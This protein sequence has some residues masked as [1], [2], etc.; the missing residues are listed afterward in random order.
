MIDKQIKVPDGM[1]ERA[2]EKFAQIGQEDSDAW[3]HFQAG[4]EFALQDI[5]DN[6]VEPT[7]EQCEELCHESGI[8]YS[9]SGKVIVRIISRE[10]QRR[11]FLAPEPPIPEYV[12]DLLVK[13]IGKPPA[14]GVVSGDWA[15]AQI[16]EAYRR[17]KEEAK[18]NG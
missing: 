13:G 18:S 10:F 14:L 11:M 5:S 6:P 16:I 9:E 2:K 3:F 8:A 7:D 17:G 12:K 4:M 15:N 1:R